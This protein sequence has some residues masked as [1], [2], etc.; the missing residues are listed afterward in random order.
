MAIAIA[1]FY[2]SERTSRLDLEAFSA[3]EAD[4]QMAEVFSTFLQGESG[5]RGYLLTQQQP[6]LAPYENARTAIFPL[7]DQ[8]KTRIAALPPDVRLPSIDPFQ[9]AV[10]AKFEELDRTVSLTRANRADEAMAI[11]R[12]DSGRGLTE[13]ARAFVA[14]FRTAAN[15]FRAER[16][17]Q[18]RRS[19]DDL[20]LVTTIGGVAVLLISIV[21][22]GR[23]RRYTTEIEGAR[24]ALSSVNMELER[25]VAT[26]TR[27]LVRANDE[28][29][30]YAYIVS[31]DLRA[32][33]VNI[34][35]FTSELE[36][37]MASVGAAVA[38]GDVDRTSSLWAPAVEA[39]EGDIPEAL[40]FIKSSINRMDGLINAILT[41]SRLGRLPLSAEPVDMNA[42]VDG[43]LGV[44]RHRVESL[45][46]DAVIEG[47]LP[48]L[49]GDRNSLQQ[50]FANLLDNA[51]KYLSADRAGRIRVRGRRAAGLVTYEVEDNG[52]GV[53]VSDQERIFE[54][55]RR[56]GVQDR[57]GEGIGLAHVRSLVRRLG[58]DVTV[59]SD[60]RSGTTFRVTL[61]ENLSHTLQASEQ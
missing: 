24:L 56:A 34:M 35:G 45:D 38:Q 42:L 10:R 8:L 18:A 14:A 13:K 22:M 29:Q 7:L 25:R 40:K 17:A 46:V 9:E 28:L 43:C 26:R 1:S 39:I 27:D 41:L 48:P 2:F 23:I 52:R 44:V 36:Q 53:S 37:S 57:P 49:I 15:E 16:I 32:P 19:A 30:R 54:L 61:P 5:Q 58:G 47:T 21:A 59:F 33:L 11:V 20:E 12:A 55:F 31:H 51:V 6:Y 50:V 60:G 4:R 3:G